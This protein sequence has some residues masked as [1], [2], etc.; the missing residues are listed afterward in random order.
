ML[1]SPSLYGVGVDY[2]ED[3]PLL[4]QKRADIVHSAAALLEK[5]NLLK[6]DRASGKFTSTELGRIA[7]HFYVT[8]NSMA[9]YNQHLR[10]T[11]STLELFR[12]FALSNE[13]K[14]IPVRQDEKL[15]LSK[16]LERVP[17]P[18]KESVEEPAAKINVLLQAYISQLK[19]DGFA[20]VADMVFV[21][22]SA[23]RIMRAMYEICLKRGW[24]IPA[25]AALDLCKMVEKR[26]WGSMTPLRQFRGVPAEVI[27]KAEGKQFPWYRYFDLTPPEIGE[28][29]GIQNAGKL[30]HRLVHSFPKLQ[31]Q[32]Q[33]QP[34]TRSLLRIDLTITPD[35]RW[36]ENIH[37]TSEQFVI[38]VED[39]DGEI[40][41]FSDNFV[42]RQRYAED[43]HSVTI[44]VPMFEP[45]P[46]NYYISVIS[47]RWLHAE[48]RLPISFKH[49]ILPAKFPPPTSLLDLQ[50]L[51]LSALHNKEF[52]S[53]YS[54]GIK[55]FNKIQTQVFQALYTTDDN[56]FI[57]APT[58]SGK[59]ICAEFALLRLWSKRDAPRAVCIEPFQD[60]VDQRVAEWKAK[61]GDLQ[62]GKEIV[63]LTGETSADLR[64]LEKGDV[65]V[66]T[67]TQWDVLSRRWRQ[68]KN[69]QNIGLLI[70][71]EI[72]L[73]GGE[74]GP[75]YEVVISRTRYVSAQTEI[76][77]RIVACGV[78]LANARD[79]GDWMGVPSHA[80][81]NFPPSARPLDM[82]IH[83]QSFQIPHFPSLM[84][85]M[86]KPAY[87]AIAEHSAVKPVIVFVPSRKQCA[88]T[89]S[90]LQIHCLADGDEKRF[91]N[92][93]ESELRRHLD[94]VTDRSLAESLAYGVGLYHEALNKQD[95]R[96]VER[97]FQ[98]GAIQ[99]VVASRVSLI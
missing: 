85:A 25:R 98:A 58:G 73:V 26:M 27:R 7:S 40:I 61:F 31:L 59:T 71:D 49:L 88:M 21:Q 70:A 56:V 67:P 24:A 10:P 4:I 1:K 69:V 42:L 32:A 18:V 37:G 9:T 99:V 87:L 35:F 48:T 90:D 75:T 91:L 29:I 44:T 79:L 57:G 77:T 30:V 45:V 93:E 80:I 39:V 38:M 82:D 66:C 54:S 34:I 41:L 14:L 16:L 15:E 63:R 89:A 52:E 3:D 81:F 55:N 97:L 65:I 86:S 17:I 5:C 6:Y 64:L 22:Q 19:L 94:H 83:L 13:F 72:Q 95:K 33:V 62:G 76:K 12:V 68:R 84:I 74:I 36:D 23:G 47:E 53:I 92:L 46:P 2:L 43:D 11:M 60:M 51:P 96:I 28:L 78:S 20:L 50:P 8:Y